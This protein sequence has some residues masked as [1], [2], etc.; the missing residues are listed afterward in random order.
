MSKRIQ[1][2]SEL[3]KEELSLIFLHKLR[4][5]APELGML[6]ITNVRVTPDLKIARVYISIF[7]KEGREE[8]IAKLNELKGFIKSELA[9]KLR[10]L[11]HMPDL[12]FYLDDTLDYV[13]KMEEI[14][15]KIHKNDNE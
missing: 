7:D 13:E 12:E 11:R 15:K 6:T 4:D 8:K 2:V 14:F 3:V 10:H 1:R 5:R 9:S